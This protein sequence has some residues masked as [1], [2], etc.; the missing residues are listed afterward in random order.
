MTAS[1][2]IRP[3]GAGDW[4]RIV[5]LL[6]AA[7]LPTEDLEP[8]AVA[9]FLVAAAG[10]DIVGAVTF[11][12]YQ[13]HALLRSLVVDADWRGH[14]VG[15]GLVEAAEAS[16]SGAGLESLTLLT[17][18]AAPLFRALGYRDIPR[19]QAPALVRDSAEFT[20]LCPSSSDCLMKNLK[21]RA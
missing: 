15:R 2:V 1:A 8:A 10:G 17:Q 7:N 18:T 19:D 13:Q 4:S 14:G 21:T 3:A 5:S 16:A 6:A 12:R 20:H 11:E 9:S